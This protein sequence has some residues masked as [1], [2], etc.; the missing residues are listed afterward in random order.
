LIIPHFG[1]DNPLS[2]KN[3]AILIFCRED[4]PAWRRQV[5]KRI[6][7]VFLFLFIL[8]AN[9]LATDYYVKTPANGGSD[10][11]DGLSWGTAKATIT[12]AMNLI[13]NGT[14]NTI[15]VAA[16]TYNEKVTFRS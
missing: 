2:K 13:A 4:D 14:G 11:Y 10:G 7:L 9:A 16:G 12:A 1:F 8:S 6:G 15:K 3:K 5:M